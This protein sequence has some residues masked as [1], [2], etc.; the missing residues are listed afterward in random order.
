[1]HSLRWPATSIYI[2]LSVLAV[3]AGFASCRDGRE[4]ASLAEL[5]ADQP[6]VAA[7]LEAAQATPPTVVARGHRVASSNE[8]GRESGAFV[9]LGGGISLDVD[10]DSGAIRAN[11]RG[12]EVVARHLGDETAEIEVDGGALV[13]RTARGGIR[14][15]MMSR[16]GAVEDVIVQANA[17]DS[18]GYQLELPTGWNVSVPHGWRDVAEIKDKSSKPRLRVAARVA[19]DSEGKEW[20]VSIRL[21]GQRIVLDVDAEAKRPLLIDPEWQPTSAPAQ[22]RT[23]ATATLLQ[24]GKVL[25][26]GGATSNGFTA[27][28]FCTTELYDPEDGSWAAGPPLPGVEPDSC[29]GLVDHVAVPLPDGSV[30]VAGGA[31]KEALLGADQPGAIARAWRFDP[32]TETFSEIASMT[33]ARVH[34]TATLLPDGKVLIAGGTDRLSPFGEF[35]FECPN[36]G[37]ERCRRCVGNTTAELFDPASNSFSELTMPEPRACHAATLLAD[38]SVLLS[39]GGGEGI[40]D[41]GGTAANELGTP[42]DTIV[43]YHDGVFTPLETKLHS[44]RYGHIAILEPQLNRLLVAFGRDKTTFV[45]S[46]GET[47][48]AELLDVEQL[49]SASPPAEGVPVP[50]LCPDDEGGGEGGAGGGAATGDC[51]VGRTLPAAVLT[52]SGRALIA[53]GQGKVADSNVE[54]DPLDTVS[55]FDFQAGEFVPTTA[56]IAPMFK[57]VLVMLPTG[58]VLSLGQTIPLALYRDTEV[59]F[60]STLAMSGPRTNHASITLRDGTQRIFGGFG[61]VSDALTSVETFDVRSE[62][63]GVIEGALQIGRA[64]FSATLLPG[65]TAADDRVLL[66]GGQQ[67]DLP[68]TPSTETTELFDPTTGSTTPGPSLNRPRAGHAAVRL[69]NGDVLVVGGFG[70]D[71]EILA[72]AEVYSPSEGFRELSAVSRVFPSAT[73]LPSGDVLV[74]GGYS[75]FI[76][77]GPGGARPAAEIYEART[78]T[79]RR[80]DDMVVSRSAHVAS[81]LPSGEVLLA[82]GSVTSPA[83]E[84]FDPDTETFR[85]TVGLMTERRVQ[86][87]GTMLPNGKLLIASGARSEDAGTSHTD[88]EIFDPQSE[89]FTR[90]PSPTEGAQGRFGH[91]AALLPDGRIGLFGGLDTPVTNENPTASVSLVS[92]GVEGDAFGVAPGILTAPDRAAPAAA[93]AITGTDLVSY[94]ASSSGPYPSPTGA[95]IAL[96]VPLSGPP[97]LGTFAPWSNDGADWTPPATPQ[98]GLGMLFAV[99]HGVIS[100]TAEMVQIELAD[101]GVACAADGACKSGF[102]SDNVCCDERCHVA[103]DPDHACVACSIAK[104]AAVDGQC[105]PVAADTDPFEDCATTAQCAEKFAVCGGDG[106]CKQCL[107]TSKLD[108]ATGYSCTASGSCEKPVAGDEVDGCSTAPAPRPGRCTATLLVAAWL[109]LRGRRIA[110]KLRSSAT[111]RRHEAASA[112]GCESRALPIEQPV[113]RKAAAR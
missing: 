67:V 99:R 19:W 53:G 43:R 21:D 106:A 80:I 60:S 24:S 42:L 22:V 63:F 104:G 48:A 111:A 1:M 88:A 10:A 64:S 40:L 62:S 49:L 97:E 102:C 25:V 92:I 68:S 50:V 96:W 8:I 4:D 95:P 90:V 28:F 105:G 54:N 26:I 6:Q 112:R 36:V 46:S 107:C 75:S 39:G 13:L 85:L 66:I 16:P 31:T 72:T 14:S 35:N 41:G 83:A 61:T 56:L 113:A 108:C 84:I 76:G 70:P 32:L 44:A 29:T 59:S 7:M 103:G 55:L 101:D 89:T 17:T 37:E 73:L 78:G 82:G 47:E 5:V 81:V 86:A 52:R 23:R 58:D 65:E 91:T 3:G 100:D 27:E 57:P 94:W 71:R 2:S 79:L 69:A 33:A 77:S 45:G 38:G 15:L 93:A 30:L 74:T 87:T 109:S 98:A 34:H 20:P 18:A 11:A 51:D 12:V 9:S 110:R